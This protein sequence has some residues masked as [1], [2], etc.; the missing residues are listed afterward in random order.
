M[1][2]NRKPRLCFVSSS[3]GHWEQLQKLEPL[4]EK[5]GGF[6]VTEKTQFDAPLVPVGDSNAMTAA[7]I[8]LIE[9]DDLRYRLSIE[10]EKVKQLLDENIIC[11]KWESLLYEENEK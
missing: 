6:F 5:Y 3:G 9:N 8:R 10:A 4:A 2:H 1:K 11:K 7:I